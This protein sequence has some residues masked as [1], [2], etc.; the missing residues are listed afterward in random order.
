MR[1]SG[2]GLVSILG[3]AVMALVLAH[4]GACASDAPLTKA[5][6][7]RRLVL[8]FSDDFDR[9]SLADP[10]RPGSGVWRTTFGAS[11]APTL[12][13][14]TLKSNGE[15]QLYVDPA[16]ADGQG[17]ALG[18]QPFAVHDGV[19]DIR[20]DRAAPAVQP[21][22]GGYGYT[23]GLLTTQPSFAQTYGY[24]E[25]RVKLPRGKGLWPAV[26]LLPTDQSWPPEIDVMESIGDPSS[27]VITI[28]TKAY[29]TKG[30]EVH[31]AG[32]GFH[33]FAVEWDAKQVV[34]YLD[35]VET[36]RA[37]TPPDMNKPMYF[38]LNLAIGGNWPGAPDAE[39]PFPAVFSVDYVR[40][41][42]FAD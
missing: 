26:W 2:R 7:G 29:P 17:R 11:P 33:T 32:D 6:D 30:V 16:L 14:R 18:L 27:A 39:T 22:L 23:S 21:A 10:R 41:Y 13:N 9:L 36:S 31:P 12:D 38:L 28:H 1:A 40:A 24:F 15:L 42:K 5:P 19:L 20:G 37:S 34:S 4:G 35:G 3:V 8:T 25:A